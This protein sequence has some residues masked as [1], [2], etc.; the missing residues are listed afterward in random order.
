MHRVDAQLALTESND[1]VDGELAVD[2][3]DELFDVY[4]PWRLQGSLAGDGETLHLHATDV[5][6][7]EWLLT[8]RF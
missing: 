5:E 8:P 4:Y 6:G 2:G 7:G 3:I 1:A